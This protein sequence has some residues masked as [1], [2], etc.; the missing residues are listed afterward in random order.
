MPWT[1]NDAERHTQKAK[2][3]TPKELWAKVANECLERTG[4]EGRDPG[5]ERSGRA[6]GRGQL[7][8]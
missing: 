3:W 8:A 2:T 4:D 6:A 1:P 7:L 5:S